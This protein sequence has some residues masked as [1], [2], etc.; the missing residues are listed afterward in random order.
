[1]SD[2]KINVP[3]FYAIIPAS[4]RYD[5]D[6]SANAKLLYGEITA[7]CN[8][9]GYCFA[10][11]EYFAALYSVDDRTIRRWLNQLEEKNYILRGYEVDELSGKKKRII[12]LVDSLLMEAASQGRTKMSGKGGQKCPA[13]GDKNVRHNN[14]NNNN[15]FNISRARRETKNK[16]S[17]FEQREYSPEQQRALEEALLRPRIRDGDSS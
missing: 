10:S 13:K 6:L 11:N 5:P 1:M 2:L 8:A 17:N 14:I 7:L 3:S 15:T 16:F 12:R 4:V 9:Y